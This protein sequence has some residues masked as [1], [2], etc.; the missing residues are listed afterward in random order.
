MISQCP[1]LEH[2]LVAS[3][4]ILLKDIVAKIG[5]L[6]ELKELFCA[7]PII[8]IL[9]LSQCTKLQSLEIEG[10]KYLDT[11][12]FPS[13]ISELTMFR[14]V[15]C[16]NLREVKFPEAAPSLTTVNFKD[17]YKLATVILPVDA[18]KLNRLETF[19]CHSLVNIE[20]YHPKG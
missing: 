9:D 6:T 8:K 17:C 20:N 3:G 18:P 15:R 4:E 2:L 19:D 13:E 1:K 14:C 10:C 7:L 12:I 5:Q 16:E 11:I